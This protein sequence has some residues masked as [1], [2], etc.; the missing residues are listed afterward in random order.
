MASA[1]AR[2]VRTVLHASP[3]RPEAVRPLAPLADVLVTDA[4]GMDALVRA[5]QPPGFGDFTGGQIHG[6][7]DGK[8]AALCHALSGGDCVLLLGARGVFV[9]ERGGDYKLIPHPGSTIFHVPP[10]CHD[11]CFVG[12]LCARL[13]AGDALREAVRTA[14]DAAAAL[15]PA[16]GQQAI[17]GR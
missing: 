1:H 3:P 16:G 2:G 7:P 5:I 8:L 4:A 10:R 13:D 11:E 9:S 15:S 6:M 12:V 17:R 14:L